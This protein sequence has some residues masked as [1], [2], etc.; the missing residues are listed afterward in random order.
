M[1][2]QPD[3]DTSKLIEQTRDYLRGFG[4]HGGDALRQLAA[5]DGWQRLAQQELEHRAYRLIQCFDDDILQAIKNG[6]ID[7]PSLAVEIANNK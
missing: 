7:I 2:N 4:S 6:Q 3:K 1:N 5:F